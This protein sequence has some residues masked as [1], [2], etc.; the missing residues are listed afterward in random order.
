M[1]AMKVLVKK[2]FVFTTDRHRNFDTIKG[3]YPDW[4]SWVFIY[5][6]HT[7]CVKNGCK[8]IMNTS[9]YREGEYYGI[10]TD[11]NFRRFYKEILP[12]W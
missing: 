5:V 12:T 3:R 8:M 10:L 6:G 4:N 11:M 9:E 2:G 7:P 1:S